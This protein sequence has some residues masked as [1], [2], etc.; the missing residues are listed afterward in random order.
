MT[1]K[2]LILAVTFLFSSSAWANVDEFLSPLSKLPPGER[3]KKLIEGAKKEG[4]VVLYSSSGIEEI[5]AIT[6]AFAKKYP[7]VNIR[8][9]RHGGSQLFNVAV[10]E[11]K[12]RKY[13]AD[14]YWAG[15][16]TL[17][18]I[19]KDEKPMLARYLSPERKAVA[20]EY[21]DRE[22]Y[23]TTTRISV[24]IFAYHAKAVPAD[25][26]P[27]TFPD[28]LDPFW[29]GKLAVDTNP[30]RFPLLLVERTGWAA[31]EA[32]LKKLAQ[33]DLKIHRGRSA[34]MQL[35][36]AGEILGSLDINADNIV[37]M[38]LQ[39]APL[40][41]AVMDPT[42]LSLTSIAMSQKSP[43]PHAAALFYDFILSKEGQEELSKENNVP[44]RDDVEAAAKELVRRLKEA[45]AQK[46][47]V[48]QSPGTYDPAAEE[49]LDRLYI[50]I[51]VKKA[52]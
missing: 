21:K 44:I 49:K 1:M 18:P 39:G 42:L 33:Q 26:V 51:L 22:G 50:D 23:W 12:A 27:K 6:K 46:K 29:K 35:I 10:M 28:L 13:I 25:K 8:F 11:F 30:G 52:K 37:E 43:H 36:L 45:R 14:V 24:S 17:G 20:D 31:A 9:V 3:Q 32:Y 40:E 2:A 19:V 4:E 15:V 47:L 5:R 41:Y 16:S 48:V 7:S 38:Q 34:R